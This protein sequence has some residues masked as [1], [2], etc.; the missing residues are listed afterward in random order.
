MKEKK[1]FSVLEEVT[2]KL[3]KSKFFDSLV[4]DLRR[5]GRVHIKPAGRL[6]NEILATAL[7]QEGFSPAIFISQDEDEMLFLKQEIVNLSGKKTGLF[8]C[9]SDEL[10]TDLDEI[11]ERILT[12]N[13]I[14]SENLKF[15][16]TNPEALSLHIPSI[17]V[18]TRNKMDFENGK[19][20]DF[21]FLMNK[22]AEMGFSR[23][24]TVGEIGEF[25]IRGNIVDIFGFGMEY[26]KRIEFSGNKIM[27]L[28]A[29]DTFTQRTVNKEK[30]FSLLPMKENLGECPHNTILDY[31]PK[32][33]VLIYS[34]LIFLTDD[35][36]PIPGLGNKYQIVLSNE[37]IDSG[38]R[39][40][41]EFHANLSMFKEYLKEIK[42]N[43]VYVLS[44]S[45]EETRRCKYLL[46]E[47]FPEISFLTLNLG[48][49]LQL[50]EWSI[51]LF[52]DKEIFGKGFHPKTLAKE[53]VSFKPEMVS[54]LTQGDYVVHED[55]GVSIFESMAKIEYKGQLT[56]CLKL[57]YGG[58]DILYVPIG[59]MSKVSKYNG[60]DKGTPRLSNLSSIKWENKKK[61]AKKAIENMT[62]DLLNL[63]A[64]RKSIKGYAFSVDTIWQKE[65]EASFPYEETKDQLKAI[66]D[67]KNDMESPRPMDRLICGEVG[68]GK[69]EV[70]I[71]AAL[72][73]VMD[74]KQVILLSPTTI[75]CEQHYNT[76]RERLR[77]FPIVIKMLS[78]FVK[79]GEE[80][81]IIKNIASGKV[82]II[83]G[84]HKLLGKNIVFNNPGLLI[85]DEEH[86]F[87]VT[88]K[89]KIKKRRKS[90]DVLS[91][92]ATPIPRTLQFS[93]LDI[94]DFST[95][96]TPPKGRLSVTTRIIHWRS[97]LVREVIRNEIKRGGQVFFVHNR[98]FE[99]PSLTRR[100]ERLVPEAVISVTH[101]RM[102]SSAIEER[103]SDFLNGKTNLLVT[104]TIIESG[105]DIANTNT[106]II[107]RADTFGLAQ[108]HQ[109]RGRVG[110]SNRKGYCYLVI[111]RSISDEARKRLSTIYNH[112]HLGSGLA[113][114]MNDL[115]IRGAGNLLG[116][117]QH[118]HISNIGYDLYM[119]LLQETA[120]R[121]KGI[122]TPKKVITEIYSN[123][124]AYLPT[125]Y[126]EDENSR[127]DIY[128]KL[129]S[130]ATLTYIEEIDQELK[131][132]FGP[133][134]LEVQTLLT[135]TKI[136][137]L[138]REKG[139]RKIS[140]KEDSMELFFSKN[141]FPSKKNIENLF[142]NVTKKFFINYSEGDFRI[143]FNTSRKKNLSDVK[144]VLHFLD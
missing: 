102:Q 59:A 32:S 41:P 52:T 105:L 12:L 124:P 69:T 49:G 72:K 35:Y 20:F 62:E 36:A 7:Q 82:D 87:G 22:L 123:L 134:P 103:M 42:G 74:S 67:I 114:A 137:V 30:K 25:S 125:S 60:L 26:P 27:S 66:G 21:S 107:N 119:K 88:Q 96:E 68:Y 143:G 94:R 131:D 45:V 6:L 76:F 98:V 51:Y 9:F 61:N 84:T 108:L 43:R 111:P 92:S 75:L 126:V 141:R 132:R 140:L 48:E 120:D 39:R 34:E 112:S 91:M 106:I 40:P 16:V 117:K 128:R 138:C 115:K 127:I 104:T 80:K 139:M 118:G 70:A 90:L 136:K 130:C 46:G 83:I 31:L 101:G 122:K 11:E 133:P 77:K 144:K 2:D 55:Y 93:L 19:H 13:G 142:R 1:Q 129:S 8:Y 38:I 113:L 78:R 121:I 79:R 23:V 3:K 14:I 81:E 33:T 58:G 64:E 86:R 29:F 100:L 109:L 17:D 95:I 135:L 37:G 28:R 85:I 63:Y 15:I 97:E 4:S 44:E 50:A 57:K 89:E 56:E 99:L 10:S 53:E 65:L 116:E 24:Q 71:R 54:E 5:N 47:D 110:R 73:A 18:F